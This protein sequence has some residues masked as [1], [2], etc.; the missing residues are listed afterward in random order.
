[1]VIIKSMSF[2]N[3]SVCV[4]Y[5]GDNIDVERC[6]HCTCNVHLFDDLWH[7]F[8]M[9]QIPYRLTF[10]RK[11]RVRYIYRLETSTQQPRHISVRRYTYIMSNKY[12]LVSIFACLVGVCIKNGFRNS[13]GSCK[14]TKAPRFDQSCSDYAI[15]CICAVK[16]RRWTV[17][18]GVLC[19]NIKF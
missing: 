10:H 16:L 6:V 1:M 3:D 7:I 5:I 13:F 8:Y 11:I 9:R 12:E 15:F 17:H 2:R 18:A 14:H 19:V 4:F